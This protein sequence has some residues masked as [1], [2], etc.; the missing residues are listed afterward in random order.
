MIVIGTSWRGASGTTWERS[1]ALVIDLGGGDV[2]MFSSRLS[3]TLRIPTS[4]ASS[5]RV[6][7]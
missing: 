1:A 6:A 7:V 3:W 2:A 5:S 4:V